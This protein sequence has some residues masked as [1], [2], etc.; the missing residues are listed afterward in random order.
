MKDGS[1]GVHTADSFISPDIETLRMPSQQTG[2]QSLTPGQL[3]SWKNC[4]TLPLGS[5]TLLYLDRDF[6]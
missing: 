6:S 4:L 1:H 3:T 5:G 2:S